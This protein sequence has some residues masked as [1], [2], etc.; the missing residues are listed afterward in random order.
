MYMEILL[1]YVPLIRDSEE[2]LTQQSLETTAL[3]W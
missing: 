1:V 2:S 3:Q